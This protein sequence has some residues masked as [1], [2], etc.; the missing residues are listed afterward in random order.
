M[1]VDYF[2]TEHYIFVHGWIPIIEN[3][4]LYDS[5]WRTARKDRW[6]KARWTRPIDMLEYEIF[7]PNK[8]I[9]CGH[10]HCSAFWKFK[11]PDKYDEFG[12]KE[13]FEPFITENVIA[14]DTC[15][16]HTR[17]VNVIILED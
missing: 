7:E 12:E 17:K 16:A 15:T 9:V 13:N 14:L 5:E 2:E 10:W 1:C 4:Y 6:N 8:T 11:Y 3:C